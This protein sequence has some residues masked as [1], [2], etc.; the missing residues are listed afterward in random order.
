MHEQ[1]PMGIQCHSIEMNKEHEEE[2][3]LV[4]HLAFI[5]EDI[6]S[7]VSDSKSSV[8]YFRLKSSVRA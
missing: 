7:A 5:A 4:F 3:F 8:S 2:N 1:D 6:L